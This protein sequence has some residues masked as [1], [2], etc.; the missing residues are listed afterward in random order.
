MQDGF[1]RGPRVVKRK[2]YIVQGS[3]TWKEKRHE[4]HT[5]PS[6]RFSPNGC[7]LLASG[8]RVCTHAI[9]LDEYT[10]VLPVSPTCLSVESAFLQAMRGGHP[11]GGLFWQSCC[12]SRRLSCWCM[13]HMCTVIL[14][15]PCLAKTKVHLPSAFC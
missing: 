5:H 9:V 10:F 7:G 4:P 1:C 15:R 3:Q 12:P 8:L 2:L 6:C 11:G 14:R 13:Y